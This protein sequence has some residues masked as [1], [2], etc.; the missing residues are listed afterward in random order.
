MRVFVQAR[1]SK[2]CPGDYLNLRIRSVHLSRAYRLALIMLSNAEIP[3]TSTK[4]IFPSLKQQACATSFSRATT[5]PQYLTS[6][7]KY[8]GQI[9]D[10]AVIRLHGPDRQ[11]IEKITGK[12]WSQIV[13]PR[14][15]DILTLGQ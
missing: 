14:N 10:M 6:T 11:G 4:D 13:A 7:K 5:C 12:D 9:K 2:R 3:I 1:I 8:R 15:E